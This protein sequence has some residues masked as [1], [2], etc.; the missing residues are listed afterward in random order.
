MEHSTDAL[1]RPIQAGDFVLRPITDSHQI[2]VVN[3]I[4]SLIGGNRLIEIIVPKFSS[5]F[6]HK[7]RTNRVYI[8]TTTIRLSANYASLIHVPEMD[9][10]V[11]KPIQALLKGWHGDNFNKMLDKLMD[12]S[13]KAKEACLTQ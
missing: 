5:R 9:L 12:L 8:T 7:T 4:S 6:N 1:G 11:C 2:A 3:S 10:M 13:K